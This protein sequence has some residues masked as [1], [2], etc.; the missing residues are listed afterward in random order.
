MS[1]YFDDDPIVDI[2]VSASPDLD[3]TFWSFTSRPKRLFRSV[4]NFWPDITYKKKLI[5][6]FV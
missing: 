4:L 1:S 3:D 6:W 2:L 5:P